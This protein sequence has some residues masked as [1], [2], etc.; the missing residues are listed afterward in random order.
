MGMGQYKSSYRLALL[1]Q[2]FQLITE[3]SVLLLH[4][5][6]QGFINIVQLL[7]EDKQRD[8]HPCLLEF[9]VRILMG[10]FL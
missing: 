9:P 10:I 7:C 4:C 8:T 5:R 3:Y 1:L 2:S 6:E